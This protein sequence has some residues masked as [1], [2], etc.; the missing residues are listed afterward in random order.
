MTHFL[1]QRC[2]WYRNPSGAVPDQLP[3]VVVSIV[4]TRGSPLISGRLRLPGLTVTGPPPPPDPPPPPEPP[5]LDP[6]PP[7]L[8]PPPPPPPP[9]PLTSAVCDVTRTADPAAFE[10]VTRT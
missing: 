9:P 5:P 8:E 2:H 7:P 3:V 6:P 4:R 10:A 1:R